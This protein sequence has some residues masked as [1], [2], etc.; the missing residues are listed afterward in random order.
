VTVEEKPLKMNFVWK[1]IQ[2]LIRFVSMNR[3]ELNVQLIVHSLDSTDDANNEKKNV[4]IFENSS[5]KSLKALKQV[6]RTV[7]Q[8]LRIVSEPIVYRGDTVTTS[9]ASNSN[10]NSSDLREEVLQ[11]QRMIASAIANNNNNNNNANSNASSSSSSS[12]SPTQFVPSTP[13]VPP[14]PPVP[15]TTTTRTLP[16]RPGFSVSM[17]ELLTGKKS[18]RKV[19]LKS[20]NGSPA[21]K[22]LMR[23]A[24]NFTPLKSTAA[25]IPRSPGGTPQRAPLTTV[26]INHD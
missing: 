4:E 12:S 11:L 1:W 10:A 13:F 9:T 14:P 26:S 16:S 6:Q 23:A 21:R 7:G 25:T 24:I 8:I 18:L 15:S 22:S 3:F 5:N 20:K 2:F 19:A 17:S